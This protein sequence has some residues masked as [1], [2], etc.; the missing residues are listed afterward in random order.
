MNQDK[1]MSDFAEQRKKNERTVKRGLGI[2]F[3][4]WIAYIL[5]ALALLGGGIYVVMHFIMKYW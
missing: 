4:L 2:M 5:F 3:G 1:F